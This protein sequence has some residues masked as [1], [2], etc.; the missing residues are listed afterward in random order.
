M[1]A[2][3][4]VGTIQMSKIMLQ[5]LEWPRQITT[6]LSLVT[7]QKQTRTC[8]AAGVESTE[9]TFGLFPKDAFAFQKDR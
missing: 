6:H 1:L 9:S 4:H 7:I 2:N 5:P 8:E 3:I